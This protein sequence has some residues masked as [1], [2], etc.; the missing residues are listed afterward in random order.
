MNRPL[1]GTIP[2]SFAGA[3]LDVPEICRP[4][5]RYA[6]I[7]TRAA[8]AQGGGVLSSTPIKR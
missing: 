1:G 3:R 5:F 6:D 7:E 4:G 2:D 8:V